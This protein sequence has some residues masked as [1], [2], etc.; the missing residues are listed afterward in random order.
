MGKCTLPAWQ[1]WS[2]PAASIKAGWPRHRSERRARSKDGCKEGDCSIR[3]WSSLMLGS[4]AANSCRAWKQSDGAREEV[5]SHWRHGQ[6]S[7]SCSPFTPAGDGPG[8]LCFPWDKGVGPF[9]VD[10]AHLWLVGEG[11]CWA[12]VLSPVPGDPGMEKG[13][14]GDW[15]SQE[16]VLRIQAPCLSLQLHP[17]RLDHVQPYPWGQGCYETPSRTLLPHCQTAQPQPDR[18]GRAAGTPLARDHPRALHSH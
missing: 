14:A 12:Q 15:H 11:C 9:P 18:P 16:Q 2:C 3:S 5:R 6:V 8:W 4:W 10:G 13:L 7:H 1:G 17:T